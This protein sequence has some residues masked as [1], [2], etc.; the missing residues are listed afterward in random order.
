M[1]KDCSL[2]AALGLVGDRW[3]LLVVRELMYGVHRFSGIAEQTG[4]PTDVLSARLR[5]LTDVGVVETR[6]YSTRPP[7][8]EYHLTEAGRDLGPA[9]LLLLAWGDRW[10]NEDPPVRIVHHHGEEH[11][12][13]AVPACAACGELVDAADL[14]AASRDGQPLDLFSG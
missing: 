7:R 9:L 3:S 14:T 10:V 5:K 4:A 1:R 11:P 13:V 12:L 6:P 2:A 8:A